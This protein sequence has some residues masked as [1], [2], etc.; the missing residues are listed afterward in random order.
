MFQL[1]VCF[2][3]SLGSVTQ[4]KFPIGE[5]IFGRLSVVLY[6]ALSRFAVPCAAAVAYG[7]GASGPESHIIRRLFFHEIIEIDLEGLWMGPISQQLANLNSIQGTAFEG[8]RH[9]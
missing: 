5:L 3:G 6:N 7:S 9:A 1:A 4:D 8:K 2:V